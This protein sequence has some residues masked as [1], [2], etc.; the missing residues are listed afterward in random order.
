MPT[1]LELIPAKDRLFLQCIAHTFI[2]GD[3]A[4]RIVT[5]ETPS[6][7]SALDRADVKEVVAQLQEWL[8]VTAVEAGEEADDGL[9]S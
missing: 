1:R 2:C 7:P 4:G 8:H 3:K 6:C 5:V 9:A